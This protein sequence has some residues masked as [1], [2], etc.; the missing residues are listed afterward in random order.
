MAMA[1]GSIIG[2]AVLLFLKLDIRMLL[3]NVLFR[4]R[5]RAS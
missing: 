3:T 4:R 1:V 5:N 2:A